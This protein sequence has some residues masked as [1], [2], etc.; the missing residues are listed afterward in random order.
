MTTL[1]K[2]MLHVVEQRV[3]KQGELGAKTF[4][5]FMHAAGGHMDHLRDMLRSGYRKQVWRLP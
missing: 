4:N 2:K 3:S 1:N 5:N